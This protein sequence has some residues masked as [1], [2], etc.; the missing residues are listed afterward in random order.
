MSWLQALV[1]TVDWSVTEPAVPGARL[2]D[3]PVELGR[4][5][6]EDTLDLMREFQLI[7]LDP[8]I[9]PEHAPPGLLELAS[10]LTRRFGSIISSVQEAR[11]QAHREGR[12]TMV[13]TYEYLPQTREFSLEYA[14][15]MGLADDY[16]RTGA[17]MHLESPLE[18]Q[19]LR[20]WTV[21]EV[22]RQYEGRTPRPWFTVRDRFV[23]ELG[24]ARTAVG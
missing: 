17:L 16:C 7:E 22:V 21:E 12:A 9:R 24:A 1:T 18:V 5:Q 20:R 3:Y 23:A 2:V 4:R 15:I 11:E 8:R 6:Y 10:E 19:A 14:R 13:M